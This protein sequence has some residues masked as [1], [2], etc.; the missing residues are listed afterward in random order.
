[1]SVSDFF[2]FSVYVDA[3]TEH[4]EQWYVDRFLA[5]KRGAFANPSSYFNV[6]A[7]L[8]DEEAAR[9]ALTYWNDINL[10]N[11]RENV[12]PTRHRATLVLQ[13]GADHK[14]DRVQLRKL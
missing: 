11:L 4:I 2:D 14:V 7:H 5:L 1:M 3:D 12:L 10:P 6:F 9:T 8:S 13:K